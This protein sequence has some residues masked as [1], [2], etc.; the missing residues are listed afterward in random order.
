MYPRPRVKDKLSSSE[1][2]P[3]PDSTST[4]RSLKCEQCGGMAFNTTEERA[5][6]NRK[7][8]GMK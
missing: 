8:H 1:S 3:G 2:P 4:S 7:E 5:E 6:H